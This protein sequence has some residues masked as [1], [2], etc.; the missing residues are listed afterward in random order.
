MS[1]NIMFS[2]ASNL[3]DKIERK[4]GINLPTRLKVFVLLQASGPLA[5]RSPLEWNNIFG[6]D[7]GKGFLSN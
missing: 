2:I 7:R 1:Q 3:V 6:Y 5:P 4:Q